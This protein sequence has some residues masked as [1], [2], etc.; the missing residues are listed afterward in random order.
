VHE[1]VF[2][3]PP[4]V[5]S[6]VIKLVR[7]TDP[8]SGLDK[9]LLFTVVKAAFNQRR[10]TLRN[11]LSSV[12]NMQ[13]PLLSEWSVKRAEQLS[14]EDFVRLTKNIQQLNHELKPSL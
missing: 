13:V 12:C 5:K 2:S 6:A 4:K 3:P 8:P 14:P 1:Q 9:Q 10:K 11:A 7:R